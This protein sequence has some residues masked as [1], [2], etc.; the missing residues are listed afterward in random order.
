M[1]WKDVAS[2]IATSAPLIGSIF[3]G[4]MGG[5]V[6]GLISIIAK[7]FGLKP[8]EVTPEK[9]DS[10]ISQNPDTL[11][12]LKELEYQ[13]EQFLQG[14]L[15]KQDEIH[16]ADVA[17]A[18]MRQVESERATKTRD[19]NLYILAYLYVCGY[20]TAVITITTLALLNKFPASMPDYIVFLLGNLFGGLTAGAGAVVQYFF[21]SS[22]GSKEKTDLLMNKANGK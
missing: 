6:G 16:L 8:E 7:Q 14:I 9:I 15:L 21:G 10:L 11:I 4:P 3:A 12:K 13:N 17:S 19:M 1:D 20:F 22:K 2:K 5:A 18:R